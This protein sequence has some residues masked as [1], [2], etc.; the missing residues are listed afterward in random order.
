MI[1][2]KEVKNVRSFSSAH[3]QTY[4]VNV[5]AA[6]NH[7][8]QFTFIGVSDPGVMGDQDAVKKCSLSKLIEKLPGLYKLCQT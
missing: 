6:Y 5:Q 1:S 7:S 8:C 4:G 2:K 3:Y